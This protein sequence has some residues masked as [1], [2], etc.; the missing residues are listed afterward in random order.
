MTISYEKF[1]KL[2]FEGWQER[3]A[4]YDDSTLHMTGK[5]I[6]ALITATGI[7]PCDR[8]LDV[9][10]GTGA[11]A[12]VAAKFGAKI[13]GIDFAPDMVS[14]ASELIADGEFKTADA[15][16][17]PFEDNSFDVV[18]TNFGHYHLADPE[19]AIREAARVLRTG[20][21]YGFTTWVGP[22]QS[23]GF[24]LI[25]KTIL[26]NVDPDV[27]IP[28]APDA[29]RLADEK[30]ARQVLKASG[31]D[32]IQCRTF[33]SKIVC[34]PDSFVTFLKAATVRATLVL[35]AQPV[36]IR[37]KIEALL[38]EK[39]ESFVTNGQVELPIPNRIITATRMYPEG[40]L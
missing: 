22:D 23:D 40:A 35:N 16:A 6:P 33:P 26:G 20:G 29:F 19:L 39:I 34:H 25:L 3:A 7:A 27:V 4:G 2:E 14:I 10:C 31:F 5:T 32:H 8:V 12:R 24:G 18:L 21:R 15:Q 9:C 37:T 28:S 17:L 38:R 1:E 36:K 13:S 11:V 30:V